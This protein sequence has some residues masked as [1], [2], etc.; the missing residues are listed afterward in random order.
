MSPFFFLRFLAL[1]RQTKRIFPSPR[2]SEKC[3]KHLK[4]A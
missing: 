4:I 1:Q 3:E 2:A